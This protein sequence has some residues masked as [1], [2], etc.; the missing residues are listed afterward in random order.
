MLF[1]ILHNEELRILHAFATT[2]F[3]P[4]SPFQEYIYAM[5]FWIC[6]VFPSSW[7]HLSLSNEQNCPNF[8][9]HVSTVD[10]YMLDMAE[11]QLI[12]EDL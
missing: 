7:Y 4:S 10:N 9:R 1:S 5:P 3:H 6:S 12:E 11:H 8:Q 2:Y